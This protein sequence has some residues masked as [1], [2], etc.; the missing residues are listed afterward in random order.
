MDGAVTVRALG[1]D[2]KRILS[3]VY[4]LTVK[5]SAVPARP[6]NRSLS[7]AVVSAAGSP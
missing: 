2:G 4:S 6:K 7:A 3:G 5:A 1:P